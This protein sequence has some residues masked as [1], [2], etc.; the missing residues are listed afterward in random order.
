MVEVRKEELKKLKS[1]V[2]NLRAQVRNFQIARNVAA[3]KAAFNDTEK[4]IILEGVLLQVLDT[5]DQAPVTRIILSK[6]NDDEFWNKHKHDSIEK[7]IAALKKS[8]I[9]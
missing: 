7:I 9:N 1:Q 8:I 4:L 5:R 3:A 2:L 6:F